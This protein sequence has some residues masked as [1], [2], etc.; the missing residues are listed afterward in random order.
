[1]KDYEV[2]VGLFE[3]YENFSYVILGWGTYLYSCF[4]YIY[5]A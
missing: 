4:V 1:M 2:M 5:C 3:K